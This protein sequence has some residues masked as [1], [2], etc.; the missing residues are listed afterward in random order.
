MSSKE[1]EA[2]YP[3]LIKSSLERMKRSRTIECPWK[4][5]KIRELANSIDASSGNS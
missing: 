2:K 5:N 1:I 3:H 4:S